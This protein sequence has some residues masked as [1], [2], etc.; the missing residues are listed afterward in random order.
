MPYR[1]YR[2]YINNDLCPEYIDDD[3]AILGLNSARRAVP[4]WNWAN[5]RI[6]AKQRNY[7]AQF[8]EKHRDKKWRI[9]TL[10]HPI[11]EPTGMPIDTV[12]FGSGRFL[13]CLKKSGCNL[14]LSGH[15]HHANV[16]SEKH[17]HGMINFISASTAISTR[18]R[19]HSN[20]FNVLT[21]NKE[22]LILEQVNYNGEHF[23]R[24]KPQKITT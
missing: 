5:G 21:L 2:K 13:R 22:T 3:V 7:A 11:H 19:H 17:E 18:I 23:V 9:C 4:H 20:G 1:R 14:V 10:H 16:T 8:F 12:V 24:A 15:L 6:S